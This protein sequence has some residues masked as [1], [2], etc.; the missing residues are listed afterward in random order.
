M[1]GVQLKPEEMA[2]FLEATESLSGEFVFEP[3]LGRAK[4]VFDLFLEK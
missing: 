1:L 2:E 4:Q 3:L